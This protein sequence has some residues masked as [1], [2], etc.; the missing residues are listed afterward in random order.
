MIDLNKDS[1]KLSSIFI[2]N[3]YNKILPE[4]YEDFNLILDIDVYKGSHKNILKWKI[5]IF[6]LLYMKI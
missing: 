3:W 2:Q 5:Q 1:F 6:L 4:L